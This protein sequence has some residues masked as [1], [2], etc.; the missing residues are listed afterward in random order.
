MP[1]HTIVKELPESERPYEKFL[2]YGAAQLSDAEL[3]AIIIK[4]G[5]KDANSLDIARIILTGGHGNLLNLYEFSYEQLMQ[6]PGIGKVKAIQLKAAAELS[7]RIAMTNRGYHIHIQ[8]SATIADYYMEQ[9]RHLKKEIVMCAFFDTKGVF[10]GD[11]QIS[12]GSTNFAYISVRDILGKALEKNAVLLILLHNHPS[13]DSTPSKEDIH[14][15]EHVS[16]CAK[17][18]DMTLIDHIIIGDNEYYSFM[19]HQVLGT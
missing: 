5:T 11:E 12:I 13:G 15:T 10:L 14:I 2:Q 6:I 16:K 17:M 3:L 7:K 8:D 1:K 9:M 4:T 19:E 18:M